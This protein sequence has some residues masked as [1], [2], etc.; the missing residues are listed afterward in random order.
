MQTSKLIWVILVYSAKIL[1][2]G[3]SNLNF[4]IGDLIPYAV[5]KQKRR[6]LDIILEHIL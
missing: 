5:F 1:C 4:Y 3:S 2:K 6:A